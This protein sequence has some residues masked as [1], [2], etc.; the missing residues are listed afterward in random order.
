MESSAHTD[1]RHWDGDKLLTIGDII[2]FVERRKRVILAT[3]GAC[4]LLGI[5]YCLFATRRYQSQA[6]LEVRQPED[7]LGLNSIQGAGSQPAQPLNPLEETV[8]LATKVQELESDDLD[9][10]VINELHLQDTADFKPSF[11]PIGKVLGLLSPSG[12]KDKPGTSFLNSPA[13][14]S[15]ALIRFNRH[16]KVEVVAGTRLISIKYDNPDPELAARVVNELA[17]DLARY[18]FDIKYATTQQ[19]SGWLADQLNTVRKQ[20]E[21][22]QAREAELRRETESYTIGTNNVGQPSIYNPVI[23]QLQ[24]ATTAL[25]Q[26]EANAILRSAVAQ[27]VK[28]RDPQLISGLAGSG[29]F[30]SG[31][32]QSTTSLDLINSLQTQIAVQQSTVKSDEVVLGDNYPKLIQDR[33]QLQSLRN[34]LQAE[35]GRLADRAKNDAMI[36]QAQEAHTRADH[37][38]LIRQANTVNDKY[39]QYQIVQQEAQDARQ[40]YTDLNQRLREVG[41]TVGLQSADTTLF[42]PGLAQ[43]KPHF[44][45]VL[46]TLVGAIIAGLFFGTVLALYVEMRDDKISSA[47]VLE[48]EVGLPTFGLAPDYKVAP[49]GRSSELPSLGGRDNGTAAAAASAIEVLSHPVSPYTESMRSLRASVL[50]SRPGGAPRTVLVTSSVADEGK[51]VTALNLAA[52]YARAG[53]RTLLVETNLRNP[54]LAQR[55]GMAP[56]PEGLSLMLTGQLGPDWTSA[57]PGISNLA[58][59]PGGQHVP[60]PHELVGSEAMRRLLAAWRERYEVVVID[61]P[62][63][64]QAAESVLLANHVDLTLLVVRYGVTSIHSLRRAYQLLP[65]HLREHTGVLLNHVSPKSKAYYEYYGYQNSYVDQVPVPQG[66]ASRG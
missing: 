35:I 46:L 3:I 13:R 37:D 54:V 59:I 31:N 30:G 11:D 61:G 58:F 4:L 29:M 50:L 60:D 16:L 49:S 43:A 15:Q 44:P 48:S 5:L 18:G 63:I 65:Q 22:L 17:N 26:A 27:I 23:D 57:V 34:A 25:D 33:A 24:Q 42:A 53:T 21:D 52:T 6:L 66:G 19:L 10:Q 9:L 41:V 1:R 62:P 45:R 32:P 20:A 12:K 2:A 47:R 7:A 51:S 28:T 56:S 14:R 39:L 8:T 55:L 64:L 36:A 38:E 40:F